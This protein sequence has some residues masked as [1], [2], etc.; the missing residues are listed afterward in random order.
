MRGIDNG[1]EFTVCGRIPGFGGLA[2]GGVFS[3]LLLPDFIY[4]VPLPVEFAPFTLYFIEYFAAR[5]GVRRRNL[6]GFTSAI[7]KPFWQNRGGSL[8][9]SLP[10]REKVGFSPCVLVV[11][12]LIAVQ[13]WL[14]AEI[15][16]IRRAN[17]YANAYDQ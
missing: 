2:R 14:P 12:G 4:L 10:V 1:R 11:Q 7:V 13:R 8:C 9:H 17:A 6:T 16:G 15:A 3:E 5:C